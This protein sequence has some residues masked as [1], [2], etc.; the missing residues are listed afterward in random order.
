MGGGWAQ[1]IPEF[2]LPITPLRTSTTKNLCMSRG[3]HLPSFV[4]L[5]SPQMPSP[6]KTR[7][8]GCCSSAR[9]CKPGAVEGLNRTLEDEKAVTSIL[10]TPGGTWAGCSGVLHS[11]STT[12]SPR[13]DGARA[14]K[15]ELRE[16]RSRSPGTRALAGLTTWRLGTRVFCRML[17]TISPCFAISKGLREKKSPVFSLSP[18][19]SPSQVPLCSL[20]RAPS[21]KG[22]TWSRFVP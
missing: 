3:S 17:C 1:S 9:C 13:K 15:R 16:I 10:L 6:L 22:S 20:F 21:S 4:F 8:C 18:F 11:P 19:G 2:L 7:P 12:A 14:S 5:C